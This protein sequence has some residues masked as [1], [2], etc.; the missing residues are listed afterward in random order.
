MALIFIH[1]FGETPEVFQAIAERL[2]GEKRYIDLWEA[3]GNEK[4]PNLNV[5]DFCKELIERF[6]ISADD[7]VV[8]HS[9]GGKL[10]WH[11]KHVQGN[12]ALQ[13]ASWT[14]QAKLNLPIKNPKAMVWLA[15]NGFMFTQ[16]TKKYLLSKYNRPDTHDIYDE[17]FERLIQGN[18]NCTVN[19]LRLV[20]ESIDT[21]VS[22]QPDLRVH[23]KRDNIVRYPSEA[24]VEVPGDHF[25][26][27]THPEEVS[28]VILE[29]LDKS[30]I[31]P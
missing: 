13:I 18:R 4:R 14:D 28:L 19:Q 7:V 2:P 29:F 26:L 6:E 8:G 31:Q 24:F 27:M 23:A 9:L 22:V 10:A 11:I 21:S 17:T 25:S 1:G 15:Q 3:L 12:T 5:I 20:V 30:Q 16:L